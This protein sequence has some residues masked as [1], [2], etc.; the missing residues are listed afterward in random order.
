MSFLVE[1]HLGPDDSHSD[2]THFA[3]RV[4]IVPPPPGTHCSVVTDKPMR[5]LEAGANI[6]GAVTHLEYREGDQV[7]IYRVMLAPIQPGS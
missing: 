4:D 6:E 3:T 5:G 1:F 7:M 2:W